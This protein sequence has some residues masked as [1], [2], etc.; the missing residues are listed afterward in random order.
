MANALE[1]EVDFPVAGKV[2]TLC[3]TTRAIVE[4]E[5]LFGGVSIGDISA[6]LTHVEYL[7]ALLWVALRKHHTG[8]DLFATYDL[9]DKCEGGT[10]VAG[11][12]VVRALRF[13]LSGTAI[14]APLVEPDK[15][16]VA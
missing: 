2:Y 9:L 13:R 3:F 14:D 8:L 11:E 12:P 5:Q 1:G 4:V 15:A 16:G 7:A 6:K 10:Q